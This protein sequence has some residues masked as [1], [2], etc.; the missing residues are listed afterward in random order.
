MLNGETKIIAHV[1]NST[2]T[3]K[4]PMICEFFDFP[5]AD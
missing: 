4:S 3:F 1:G 5:A 2:T